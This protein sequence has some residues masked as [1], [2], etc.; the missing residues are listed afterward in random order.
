M[1]KKFLPVLLLYL[2]SEKISAQQSDNEYQLKSFTPLP[3]TPVKDQYLSATCWSFAGNSF[4]ESELLR[5]GKGEIDLSEMFTARYSYLNKINQH[6]ALNGQNTFTPGGQF[7]DI[8]WVLKHYGAVPENVYNGKPG[9]E[10]NHNHGMLDTAMKKYVKKMI[11]EGKTKPSQS[12][13]EYINGLL[14]VYLG[15]TPDSFLWNSKM[16]TP[17][18]FLKDLGFDPDNYIEITSYTHHPWYK[19]FILENE[20]NWMNAEYMNV[21]LSDFTKIT[22][23]ALEK[24]YTVLWSGDATDA[25]FRFYNAIAMLPDTIKNLESVRQRT[26]EDSSSYLD[27]VMHIVGKT[28][29]SNGQTW[30]YIKNSWG[31]DGNKAGGFLLMNELY[32]AI[33]TT[34]IVVNKQ[35]ILE[36]IRNKIGLKK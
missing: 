7:H 14:N 1:M 11:S 32:F 5:M 24:G 29:D 31:S 26:F 13:M 25:G 28:T 22:N 6:L 16:V 34:A 19:P 36:E 15:K 20:Y 21:P 23:N 10:Y 3:C 27:H 18:I 8:Q 35:A 12:D 9:G 17:S 2:F 30:Y 4:I 33:K